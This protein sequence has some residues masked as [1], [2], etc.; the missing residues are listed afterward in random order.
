[1]SDKQLLTD[2]GK[3]VRSL[4]E[5]RGLSQEQLADLAG[6]HRTYIGM[7]GLLSVALFKALA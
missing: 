3:R 4:R 1:V 7:V 2:F 5:A 6:F